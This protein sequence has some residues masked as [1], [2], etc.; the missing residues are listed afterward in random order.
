MPQA[1]PDPQFARGRLR[2]TQAGGESKEGL[3]VPTERQSLPVKAGPEQSDAVLNCTEMQGGAGPTKERRGIQGGLPERHRFCNP[4]P[5]QGASGRLSY[6]QQ[7]DE[8]EKTV[9]ERPLV[10]ALEDLRLEE[11]QDPQDVQEEGEVV[12]LAELLE[13]EVHPAVEQGRDHRQVPGRGRKQSRRRSRHASGGEGGVRFLTDP[14]T[15]QSE[16][17]EN[18]PK[19]TLLYAACH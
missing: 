18:R 11:L 4:T 10:L 19:E 13:V 9:P 14:R 12:L 8:G 5:D 1:G 15:T 7:A 17:R 6:Q 3:L 2:E 16:W